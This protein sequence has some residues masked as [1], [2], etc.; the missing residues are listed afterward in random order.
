MHSADGSA[1]VSLKNEK[2][3]AKI[4]SAPAPPPQDF[5]LQGSISIAMPGGAKAAAKPRAAAPAGDA[6]ISP[7][8][9]PPPGAAAGAQPS[10]RRRPVAG[11]APAPAPVAATDPFGA[12]PF[13]GADAF[14]ASAA[15]AG[16]TD[17]A[18]A[19][20]AAAEDA[21]CAAALRAY[22]SCLR[23]SLQGSTIEHGACNAEFDAVRQCMRH[24]C[25]TVPPS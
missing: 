14:G 11:A 25:A 20:A 13:G 3:A 12:T 23:D 15:A 8:L 22:G 5:S 21:R 9:P 17:G 7:F 24:A 19:A 2:E 6:G 1:V 4:A 18:E 10:N 16:G